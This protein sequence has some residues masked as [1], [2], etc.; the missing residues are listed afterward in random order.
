MR[1]CECRLRKP[2]RLTVLTIEEERMRWVS[3]LMSYD[4]LLWESMRP[5]EFLKGQLVDIEAWLREIAETVICH[6]DQVPMWLRVGSLRHLYAAHEVRRRKAAAEAGAPVGNE[7]GE[8][9]VECFEEDGMTQMRQ[10]A[11]SES[12][13]FRVTLE[14]SQ[15]VRSVYKPDTPFEVS[16]GVPVLIV[17]GVH[18]R[19]SNI[20]EEGAFVE[21]EVF[22]VKKSRRRGRLGIMQAI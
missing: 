8:Q 19:L 18:A 13:R 6:C 7:P 17:P 22:E 4:C 10:A 9:L 1:F 5:E 15:T 20:S 2:Q 21:D 3:S 12:D 16:H 14:L 11:S